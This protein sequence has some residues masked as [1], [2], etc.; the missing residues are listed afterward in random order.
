MR[1]VGWSI[2]GE[3]PNFTEEQ[4]KYDGNK[5]LPET[6]TN[7]TCQLLHVSLPGGLLLLLLL[8]VPHWVAAETTLAEMLHEVRS[9]EVSSPGKGI[10]KSRLP[11][12]AELTLAEKL[13]QRVFVG[14]NN[15][16]LRQQWESLGFELVEKTGETGPLLIVREHDKGTKKYEGKG[17][18]VFSTDQESLTVLQVPH[19][20]HD[21]ETEVIA[22]KLVAKNNFRAAAW[23]T[24]PAELPVHS[25]LSADSRTPSV[26]DYMLAFTRA[27]MAVEVDSYVVQLHSF[28]KNE[29]Y[30]SNAAHAD[31]ILSGYSDKSSKAI[32]WLGRCLKKELDYKV[33]IFP[34]EVQEMGAGENVLGA[35]YNAVGEL[36]QAEGSQGFVHLVMGGTFREELQSY[37]KV[38]EKMLTCLN[39]E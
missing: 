22:L 11:S 29:V 35:N 20:F 16:E 23:N 36:M 24:A 12:A 14:E 18:F 27:L 39:R 25:P 32:G 30:T 15:S 34:F 33:R 10:A 38:Q 3:N 4:N 1:R 13:F 5:A 21:A 8:A 31:I 7:R 37:P 19:S 9:T 26:R 28:E 17:F 2:L 6:L